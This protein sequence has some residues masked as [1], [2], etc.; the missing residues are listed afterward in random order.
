MTFHLNIVRSLWNLV[1]M[2]YVWRPRGISFHFFEIHPRSPTGGESP[3]QNPPSQSTGRLP[4]NLVYMLRTTLLNECPIQF[5]EI[6]SHLPSQ[7]GDFSPKTPKSRNLVRLSW[8]LVCMVSGKLL[9]DEFCPFSEFPSRSPPP[10]AVYSSAQL[11]G[12]G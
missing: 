9:E 11:V 1:H 8:N 12:E 6:P 10:H 5:S 3:P 2:F 4:W 7:G